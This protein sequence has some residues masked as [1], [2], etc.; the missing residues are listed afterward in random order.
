MLDM[1]AL[2]MRVAD[3]DGNKEGLTQASVR[4]VL[5]LVADKMAESSLVVEILLKHGRKRLEASAGST[6]SR[7]KKRRR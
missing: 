3:C 6:R 5:D 1:N 4:G 2:A 7:K